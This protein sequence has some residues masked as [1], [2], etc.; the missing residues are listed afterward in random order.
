[1]I[2]G[3]IRYDAGS[4]MSRVVEYN[5][6]LYFGGHVAHQDFK[7]IGEQTKAL[8]ERFDEL[9]EK[10]GTDKDHLLTAMIHMKDMTMIHEMNEVWDDWINDG[11]APSRTCV[12]AKFSEDYILLE[13]TI[14]A[15]KK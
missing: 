5:G 9:F 7:T 8:T 11:K 15:V 13:I 3:I 4:R 14:V 6:V 1:M 2:L 12:E 10:Y